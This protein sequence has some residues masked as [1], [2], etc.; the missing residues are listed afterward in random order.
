MIDVRSP[1]DARHLGSYARPNPD[2]LD[3]ALARAD[4]AF[5]DWRRTPIEERARLLGRVADVLSAKVDGLAPRI[6]D[7]MGKILRE[8]RAEVEKCAASLRFVAEHGPADLARRHV[9]VPSGRA[10]VAYDPLGVVLSVLPWNYPYWQ[11][12]RCAAP[13][14][15]AGNTVVFKPADNVPFSTDDLLW[16]FAEAGVPEEVVSAIRPTPTELATWYGDPRIR[17]GALTGSVRAGRSFAAGMGAWGKPVVLELGG[18]DAALILDDADVDRAA[19]EL[20]AARFLNAGQTCLA[21]KRLIAV[22]A[23]Y[24]R[25]VE[26]VVEAVRPLVSGDPRDPAT[27]LGPLARRDLV[28]AVARQVE[29]STANVG[30]RG[31]VPSDAF[32]PPVVLTDVVPGMPVFDEEVFGPVAAVVRAADEA[33]AVRLA[34]TTSFGLGATVYTADQVRGERV[35][36]E[37]VAG[38]TFVNHPVR[39]DPRLPF[40]GV[41]DSGYG[42]EL[43]LEGARTFTNARSVWIR[44]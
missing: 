21:P 35:A 30:F 2:D 23:V 32:A 16:C 27:D 1:Y 31:A 6:T 24:D 13:A 17:A 18:S 41:R 12:I 43:S 33:E 28:D 8:S 10:Y 26:R 4:A 40:G 9:A 25:F 22:G 20:V 39:S 29:T 34:N 5:Q 38:S 7:E 44:G 36:A 42:R 11:A 14:L 19:A 15:L 37:L 3:A